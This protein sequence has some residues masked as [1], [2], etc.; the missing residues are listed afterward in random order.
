MR[1]PRVGVMIVAVLTML[2]FGGLDAASAQEAEAS[3]QEAE[4]NAHTVSSAEISRT[5]A[6]HADRGADDRAVIR[7]VLE[8]SD[9]RRIARTVGI[10]L[11]QAEAA[12]ATLD[13][14]ELARVATLARQAEA[15]LVGGDAIVI[16]STALIIGLLVLLVILVA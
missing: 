3:A 1:I 4:A 6:E 7:R 13:G 2:L 9:A 10:E 5:V 12:A 14:E 11:E 8:H 16:S 15:A